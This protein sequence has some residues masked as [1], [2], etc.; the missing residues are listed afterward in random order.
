M[1]VAE[2]RRLINSLVNAY[3]SYQSARGALERAREA[4]WVRSAA[5]ELM[6]AVCPRATEADRLEAESLLDRTAV[7]MIA[8]REAVTAS[9]SEV[10]LATEAAQ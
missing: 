7:A 10:V 2:Y 5:R 8:H 9:A 3:T 4:E 6:A 1:K